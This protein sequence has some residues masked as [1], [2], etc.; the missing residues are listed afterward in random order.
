[1]RLIMA[2]IPQLERTLVAKIIFNNSTKMACLS[3]ISDQFLRELLNNE[4]STDYDHNE[5]R[6]VYSIRHIVASDFVEV[7]P[8]SIRSTDS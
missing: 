6:S 8:L 2:N 7:F 4:A 5:Q 3:H 1:M